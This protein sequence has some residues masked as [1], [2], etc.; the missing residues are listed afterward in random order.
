MSADGILLIVIGII[1]AVIFVAALGCNHLFL[2]Q[3]RK[4]EPKIAFSWNPIIGDS[5]TFITD[6]MNYLLSKSRMFSE[7][8]IFGVLLGGER[9]F[10]L[11]DPASFEVL[12]NA[13]NAMVINVFL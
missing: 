10:F 9:Y 7:L 12:Y 13:H 3:Q 6:P 1:T 5:N 4:K 2:V 8:E 11:N